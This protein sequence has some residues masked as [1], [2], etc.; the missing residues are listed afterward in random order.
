M[1]TDYNMRDFTE[2]PLLGILGGMGPAATVDFQQRLLRSSPVTRDQEHIA[3][4][5]W[6]HGAIPDRQLALNAQ[7]ESPVPA[8]L[9]GLKTLEHAG[10]SKIAIPCNTAHFWHAQLQQHTH[11]EILNMIEITVQQV[12]K[13]SKP[14]SKVGILA[15]QGA[16]TTQL[17]QNE[18]TQSHIPF[19][20]PSEQAITQQ[21]MPA[22]Y[23]VK[24][25]QLEQAG[26]V[27]QQL[28]EDLLSQ[29]AQS[30]I[31]ACTEIPLA[32]HAIQSPLLKISF[33]TTQLLANACVDWFYNK[34]G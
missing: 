34:S 24:A 32:L 14:N 29:G 4:L 5:T 3:T 31:L 26:V 15:T 9:S 18:L 22:V 17:Y 12:L 27:F 1:L 6:N 23:A 19:V 16:L 25:N 13:R 10:V 7:G 33:D 8:L 30:I 21:L 2:T 28:A 11:V 20:M